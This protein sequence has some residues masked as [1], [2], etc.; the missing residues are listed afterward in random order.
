VVVKNV[1]C[2]EPAN[3]AEKSKDYLSVQT[4]KRLEAKIA[5]EQVWINKHAT[6]LGAAQTSLQQNGKEMK[7]ALEELIRRQADVEDSKEEVQRQNALLSTHRELLENYEKALV[8]A[9][10]EGDKQ[11][12]M[13]IDERYNNIVRMVQAAE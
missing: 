7:E 1:Q 3:I 5:E 2:A 13:S 6:S 10:K 9:S 8:N 11:D 4:I 12:E